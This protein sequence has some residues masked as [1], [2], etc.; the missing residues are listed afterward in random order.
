[1]KQ[2][3]LKRMI[4]FALIAAMVA[5]LLPAAFA[6][7][8]TRGFASPSGKL[9]VAQTDYTLSK[10][11]TESQVI[12]N[13]ESGTAQVYGYLTTVDPGASVKLKASYAGYYTEGSTP[14]SRAEAAKNLKWDMRTTTGQA[15]DYEKTTGETVIMAT[16]ADYYNM[17]TAQCR[18]YLIM[19]G[20]L[21]Q[22]Q[23]NDGDQEPYFAVLKDGTYAIRDYGMPTDDVEEA[24][25]GPFYLLK[26]GNIV[27]GQDALLA[28]RNSIGLKADG[29]V[30]TFLADG[31]AGLS[32]GMTVYEVAEVMQA[33]GVV[34]AIYLDGGGSATLAS[35]HE[36]SGSLE[37]QNH[38]SDGP[39]RV[40]ASTL[41]MVSTA[42]ETGTFDHAAL[43]PK[44]EV[45]IAGAQVQFLADGVDAGGYPVSIPTNARWSLKDTS[46]GTI[47]STGLFKSNGKCGTVIVNL[48]VSNKT[49]GTTSIEIQEPT[50]V[51][52]PADSMNLAFNATSSLDL[53][54]K[55][56]T[57]MMQLGGKELDWSIESKTEGVTAEQI[58]SI[59]NNCFTTVK[60]NQTLNAVISA[61]YTKADGTVL[62]DSIAVE[63]GKMPKILW[64]FEPDKNGKV[65]KGVGQYDWGDASCSPEGWTPDET[66]IT[67]FAWEG[68]AETGGVQWK[69]E[70][71]PF[72]FDGSYLDGPT[73]VCRYPAGNVFAAAGYD[74]FT[75]RASY[76]QPFSTGGDI[77][78]AETGEVRFG[79]Y[80]LR[81]D[82]DYRNLFDGYKNVNMWLY[83]AGED[84]VLEGTPSALGFWVYAPEGTDNFWLWLQIG[85]YDENGTLNRPYVHLKTQ[86]G[87]S[88]QYNGIYWDGWMYV[89]ADLTPYA[90]YVTPEHPL[91]IC[92][93]RPFLSLTFIPGG[94]ANE[95]GDKIPMG[96][97]SN[98]SLYFDNFRLVYGDTVD[99]MENPVIS[100][101]SA[102]GNNLGGQTVEL[103][104][105][106]VSIRASFSDPVSDNATGINTEKTALY[107][108]GFKQTLTTST[109]TEAAT[110]VTLPNGTH[111]IT[112]TVSD[113]FGNVTKQTGYV[114]VKAA[115]SKL[116]SVTLSGETSA[117]LG[118][119]YA[120]HLNV[121]QSAKVTE[122]STE[123]ALNNS[124]GEP[125][126]TFENGYT[127][128]SAFENGKL[129][130]HAETERTMSGTVAK[131]TFTVDPATA[132]GTLLNY[133]VKTGSFIDGGKQYT[134]A[135][136]PTAVGVTAAYELSTDVMMVNSTGKI[137]VTTADGNTPGKVEVYKVIEGAEPLLLGTTNAAGVLVTNKLCQ[138]LGESYQIY[139]K[140]EMGYSFRIA[141]VTNGIGSDEVTP[142]NV[143][144]NA[145]A[146][147][148]TTQSITWFSA[149]E[150]TVKKAVVQYAEGALIKGESAEYT[151]VT[152]TS[153]VYAFNG[154]A[155]DNNAALI[156][157]VLLE[158]LQPGTTY[159]YRVGD[160][161]EGHWS[162][163]RQFT[164]ATEGAET[165]FFVIGDTQLTGNDTTDA[166][167]IAAM[168][169][170]A[171]AVNKAEVD[172]GIQTGDY[173]DT[174]N[175]LSRWNQI[176]SAFG[177]NYP[178][179]PIIQVLG[180]HE[181][182]GDTTGNLANTIFDLPDKDYYSVEY[183][184]VYVAVINCNANIEAAA[185]WLVE[186]AARS[187]CTWK[188]LTLHQPPYYTNP[189]GSSDPYNKGIPAAAEAAGIDFVFSG[190][191]HAYARTEP[192]A[193]G[194]VDEKNGV[195]YFI[196]GD[197][198]EKS[199]DIDYAPENNP[200]FH[201]A[202]I[203]QDYDALY[204]LVN[205]TETEMTVTAYDL[206]GTAIDSYTKK[207]DNQP[208]DPPTPPQPE[209]HHY[210]Y[211]R[212][213]G[214]L[215]CTDSG[216][217]EEA[218]KNYTGWAK[219]MTSGRNMYFLGGVYKTGWF[220]LGEELYHFDDKTGEAHN[221][222]VLEDVKTTCGEQGHKSVQCECGETNSMN[223]SLPAGHSNE[224]YTTDEGEV[225][226]VCS[227]C[228]RIS[229]YDLTFVDVNDSDW[230]AP[231]VDYVVAAKLFNGRSAVIFDP[232]TSMTRAELVSVLWR[233]A[234]SP[235]YE[236]VG[237]TPFDDCKTG[238]WYTAAVNW[239]A[240]NGIVN[241]VG[242]NRFD[243]N[244]YITREQIVTIF[245]RYAKHIGMDVTERADYTEDFLDASKVSD[246]AEDAMSWAVA[247]KLIQGDDKGNI[248]P[249]GNATRAEVAT[250]VMRFT[251]M[252]KTDE[253][254]TPDK[255]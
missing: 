106:T 91:V 229:Q 115:N 83:P 60:A 39:E 210:S 114:K 49:V 213:T 93:G 142:S 103:Y 173:I 116:G 167:A 14:A 198:G 211:D 68:D 233:N 178:S 85:Y 44:N 89:E 1:M 243:P 31:R 73:D 169:T 46:F 72:F 239:A 63:I 248:K 192:I 33:Q 224:A 18:G 88:L 150:Y 112:L 102:N 158:N 129:T 230:F 144:L 109:E 139:A 199:R 53:T 130:I 185:K 137:Y 244:G 124:F 223:Y 206:D 5:S 76:M 145:V 87:R 69:T 214:K 254:M 45:Y 154:G 189:K 176:L 26:D 241:G 253:S 71:G 236:E 225:Y 65:G 41:L 141:G 166:P 12:L 110:I 245:F 180:N 156:N 191:D 77:V 23:G 172:F 165:S 48:V 163:M 238:A 67:F 246:Y 24:I 27:V 231:Y 66:P 8:V 219:D 195:V 62:G 161:V 217:T 6:V 9:V 20:N 92:G 182:Y 35:R 57:R 108:D 201:F 218:P 197:L 174:A 2:R 25:S 168:D 188:V 179:T 155:Q 32:K 187:D 203:S 96:G 160:G 240:E 152:G 207:L 237:Y 84:T 132:R 216:C 99:D 208:I 98:G 251:Q 186:D 183:G 143:R 194:A 107:I 177:N 140:G 36:G 97:F 113:G 22:T 127:G 250:I 95:N 181:Y 43:T 21:I 234:G 232:N 153:S 193:V 58:G 255:Q 7:E 171:D 228:G 37:I 125:L 29:T 3:F 252:L 122:V 227:V 205:T 42:K 16:N 162:A 40:V 135:S 212:K 51:Y 15:A 215:I 50:E 59:S 170:I 222:T 247:V 78:T 235:G 54:V 11:V 55:Y 94:S 146:D 200:N 118:E 61:S 52:F 131:I 90:E 119:S 38:P 79:D 30:V 117:M 86:E 101:L 148:T 134:F 74:F 184:N 111:S 28:P 64:D 120:L 105:N 121:E 149:P 147:P 209:E 196:C 104:N 100:K 82:Y 138:T 136:E 126:V 75:D 226:Y 4:C 70:S 123:I 220:Q 221:L 202:K 159:H 34:D 133:E 157:T 151:T 81:M 164:T 249:L 242:D 17:Q 56:Q 128:T 204:I 47:D 175:S 19:E 80:A 13:N 10:G 190:H